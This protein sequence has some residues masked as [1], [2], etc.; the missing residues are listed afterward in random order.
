[1]D[2]EDIVKWHNCS[3]CRE[4]PRPYEPVVN[5]IAM[6]MM[7][8]ICFKQFNKEAGCPECRQTMK[9]YHH[10]PGYH[11]PLNW[12]QQ[13]FNYL[14]LNKLYGCKANLNY[15]NVEAHDK[16][17]EFL[18]FICEKKG[19]GFTCSFLSLLDSPPHSH[20]KIFFDA[21]KSVWEFVLMLER[22]FSEA[23]NQIEL[24]EEIPHFFLLRGT[25]ENFDTLFRPMFSFSM[26][27]NCQ[28]ISIKLYWYCFEVFSLVNL[29][30]YKFVLTAYVKTSVGYIKKSAVMAPVFLKKEFTA[31]HKLDI[32]FFKLI[33]K[34]F[35]ISSCIECERKTPHLHFSIELMNNNLVPKLSS[36][37]LFFSNPPSN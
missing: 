11:N 1:M 17:C 14:C 29:S 18:P 7:C 9:K 15:D 26:S 27:P 31:V 25:R 20:T 33:L 3:V 6:H 5:C 34:A 21:D 13:R 4:F 23:K 24:S 37:S 30:D 28:D 19:C 12:A 35:E 8:G 36:L 32:E 2:L 16:L 22:F 10:I